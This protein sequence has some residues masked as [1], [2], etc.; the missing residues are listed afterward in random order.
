ME[1]MIMAIKKDGVGNDRLTLTPCEDCDTTIYG[2]EVGNGNVVDVSCGDGVKVLRTIPTDLTE[3]EREI[4]KSYLNILEFKRAYIAGNYHLFVVM[5][6]GREIDLG[7]VR[8]LPG[9]TPK[10]GENGNWFVDGIDTGT[11]AQ[12][13]R[14]PVPNVGENGNWF[15][16]GVDTGVLSGKPSVGDTIETV[17]DDLGA[18]WVACDGSR[19]NPEDHPKLY[20]KLPYNTEWRRIMPSFSAGELNNSSV[21]Y[22]SVRPLTIPGKWALVYSYDGSQVVPVDGRAAVYDVDT[23]TLT[24]IT[25]PKVSGAT[26]YGIFGLTHYGDRYVLGVFEHS[27]ASTMPGKVRLYTSTDLVTWTLRYTFECA[28]TYIRAWDLSFDGVN[29][30]YM[31]RDTSNEEGSS[32]GGIDVYAIN[33]AMTKVTKLT[34]FVN[35]SRFRFVT[36]P[37]GYWAVSRPDSEGIS[38]YAA[39]GKSQLF[40]FMDGW[41]T[42]RIAFFNDRYWVGLPKDSPAAPYICAA[43]LTTNK[44]DKFY[45]A[46]LVE[47]EY[48][49]HAYMQGATY[50]RNT[51]EWTFILYSHKTGLGNAGKKYYAAYISEDANPLDKTQYRVVPVSE[52]AADE[53]SYE[54]MAPDRSQM[55]LSTSSADQYLRDPNLKYLPSTEDGGVRRYIY[56]GLDGA[57]SGAIPSPNLYATDPDAVHYYR[58]GKTDEQKAQARENIGAQPAGDYARRSDLPSKVSELENDSGFITRLVSD[59]ANYYTKAETAEM[60]SSIP[61]FAISVVDTLPTTGISDTTVY[62][63]RSGAGEDLY[64]E[65]IYVGGVWEVLGAQ[66]VDL[67][68]YATEAWAAAQ[69]DAIAQ[70]LQSAIGEARL[71]SV[72]HVEQSLTDAQKTQARKNIGALG[73]D[74]LGAAVD[75]A[76]RQAKESG[77]F[78]GENGDDYVLTEGDKT[79]IA[80]MAAGKLQPG[81]DEL[82]EAIVKMDDSKSDAI[83]ETATGEVLALTDA[84]ATHLRGLVVYGKST[85][86]GTPTPD[87]PVPIVSVGEDGVTDVGVYG[88]NLLLC[89]YREY[90]TNGVT[91]T[92]NAD[93]SISVSGTATASAY[94]NFKKAVKL[95]SGYY[96]VSGCA[97]GGNEG[98]YTLQI[99][100]VKADGS[101]GPVIGNEYGKGLDLKVDRERRVM[102]YIVIRTGVSV[103]GL[104]FRPSLVR[105]ASYDG[106]FYKP[107]DPQFLPISTPD[108]LCGIPVTSGGNYT[109]ANGQQWVC[110]EI[111]FVRGVRVQRVGVLPAYAGETVGDGWLSTTGALTTGAKVYYAIAE[112]IETP[113]TE[114]ELAAYR[115]LYANHPNT[116]IYADD[117]AGLSVDY[118]ADTKLY[119]DKKFAE[120]AEAIVNA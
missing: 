106:Q 117:N 36:L 86:D 22:Y 56:E 5:S 63:V 100:D 57:Q 99:Y 43:D 97:A 113:L 74:A 116:T 70:Q 58:D 47:V 98:R 25:C 60:I 76:L 103:D 73:E 20:D 78:D 37:N 53:L 44:V 61:K 67:T 41:Y 9:A 71:E 114:D 32:Y 85:Q 64:T 120:L 23:D 38:V 93:G 65:Y 118:K 12:G 77:E 80:E 75:D 29:I 115:A 13:E 21:D 42:P 108:G 31:T 51:R 33:K 27:S 11:H 50:D 26:Y 119:I 52:H 95:T 84:A 88:K 96:K 39:G 66:R 83:V 105:S 112:P 79:E 6:D 3:R 91:F 110:D 81:I 89:E 8:G 10:V 45:V 34:G 111:D 94:Y 1:V 62:L 90:V 40:Y 19:L 104:V 46:N 107:V 49:E 59:L 101:V 2:D 7:N 24:Y 4:V 55:R 30:L 72:K 54:Q 109:D 82:S 35:Y 87:A 17:R 68:G 48:A 16:D 92:P 69:T 18:G 102:G 14:G 28:S 15:V